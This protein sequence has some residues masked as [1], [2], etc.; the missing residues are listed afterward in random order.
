MK[1]Y[2]GI[3]SFPTTTEKTKSRAYFAAERLKKERKYYEL[4]PL[5]KPLKREIYVNLLIIIIIINNV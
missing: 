2:L 5:I 4:K 3:M 1:T